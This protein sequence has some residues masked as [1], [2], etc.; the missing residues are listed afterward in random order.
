MKLKSISGEIN[1]VVQGSHTSGRITQ[2]GGT[3]STRNVWSFR[4]N[5]IPTSFT[6]KEN[7]SLSDGDNIIAVGQEKRGT[8]Q[9][10][11]IKNETTGAFF[12]PS[13]MPLIDLFNKKANKSIF[14]SK[15]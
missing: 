13:R 12:E 7:L 11:C 5:G 14:N 8:V 9:I 6:S 2:R 4:V 3:I 10:A 1:S 15:C